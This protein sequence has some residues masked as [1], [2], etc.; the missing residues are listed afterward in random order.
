MFKNQRGVALILCLILMAVFFAMATYVSG[1]QQQQLKLFMGLQQRVEQHFLV[2]SIIQQLNYSV[3]T[4]SPFIVQGS[5]YKLNS[6][7][8]SISVGDDITLSVRDGYGVISMIPFDKEA[9]ATLVNKFSGEEDLGA[10]LTARIL[11]WQDRDSLE[12]LGGKEASFFV[13]D[14]YQPRNYILQSLSEIRLVDGMTSELFRK[15]AP[16]LIY[17][18]IAALETNA[19]SSDLRD[20]LDLPPLERTQEGINNQVNG[21]AIGVQQPLIIEIKVRGEHASLQQKYFIRYWPTANELWG[22]SEY[23]E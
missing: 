1:K 19:A 9:F 13:G 17:Y 21:L 15:L 14:N 2:D 5:E 10:K 6:Y 16:H 11:D 18:K 20:L 23:G 4:N 7:G 12:R 8:E 22:Y 3:V